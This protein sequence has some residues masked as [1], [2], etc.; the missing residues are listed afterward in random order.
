[1]PKR[2]LSYDPDIECLKN[3]ADNL[4]ADYHREDQEAIDDF[5]SFYPGRINPKDTSL[6]DAQLVLARSYRFD[7]WERL[8]LAAKLC[9]AI[10]QSDRASVHSLVQQHPQLLN[11]PV[12]GADTAA[13]WGLP[14]HCARYFGNEAVVDQ[15]IESSGR[16]GDDLI[17]QAAA[18]GN[19]LLADWFIGVRGKVCRGAVMNPCE[20]LNG[21]GLEFLLRQGADLSDGEGNRLAPVATILETYSR[22]PEGKHK[23][24]EICHEFGIDFPDTPMMAFHQGR[25]D[26]LEKHLERDSN[27]IQRRFLHHE[28]YPVEIGCGERSTGAGLH[29]TPIHGATMLHLAVDFDEKEVL[30]WLLSKGADVNATALVDT[31]GFGGHTPLFGTVVSQPTVNGRQ[32]DGGM[33][34]CLLDSGADAN[35]RASLRKGIRF[36]QNPEIVEYRDVT[37]LGWGKRFHGRDF[38]SE[39]AMSL[40]AEHGGGE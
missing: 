2:R 15:L 1:M 13:S 9:R 25:I 32:A 28:I 7:G 17:R 8:L 23:C 29:G 40:I 26:L 3:E 36:S 19:Q 31:D 4:L 14:I 24:L 16:E 30:L 18:A 35:A 38:V 27:L 10:Y 6:R 12:R 39:S 33:A 22:F 21:D 34:R 11:E 5:K 20:T 37:P